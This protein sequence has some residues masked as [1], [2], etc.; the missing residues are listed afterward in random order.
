MLAALDISHAEFLGAVQL[1]QKESLEYKCQIELGADYE[2]LPNL[3][4]GTIRKRYPLGILFHIAAGNVDG[5]PAYS[6]VEGLL[7]GNINILKLPSGDSGLSIKLLYELIKIEPRLKDFIY[8]FDVPS[9]EIETLKLFANI[10]DG[11]VVWGGDLAVKAAREMADVTTKVI[12]WGHK[13]SFAYA[14]TQATNLQLEGLA[15]HICETNQILCSS[16]QGIFVDTNNREEQLIFGK[17]FFEA[18]RRINA[19]FKKVSV[20]MRAKNAINLYNERL[21]EHDTK[22]T[23]LSDDGISVILYED[24][25]LELSY[26]F[27]NV[28]VKRLPHDH[29]VETLKY[30]KNYLQTCGLLCQDNEFQNLASLLARAG[31]VRITKG[32]DMS[33]MLSGESHDG[34][35]PLREYSR[36][37]EIG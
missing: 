11:V 3:K 21:E 23:I 8:V 2:N 28:W 26:L 1:F 27:R 18:F 34:T 19:E 12:S 29:I 7:V 5:L 22:R 36:I 32:Q 14:T 35:F 6:V 9:T 10:A 37:V 24:D 4:N 15:R 33:R 13:L 16:C 31:I 30:K 17:R 20:G 25:E